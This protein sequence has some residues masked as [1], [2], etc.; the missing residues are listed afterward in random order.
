VVAPDPVRVTAPDL[1]RVVDARALPNNVLVLTWAAPG[2]E[3]ARVKLKDYDSGART[4]DPL[5]VDIP[6]TSLKEQADDLEIRRSNSIALAG[7][8][9][10][11]EL[12]VEYKLKTTLFVMN[13]F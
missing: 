7:G 5:R 3:S 4:P 12:S 8:L 13:P 2:A 1:T 6:A 11:S 10:G 9:P